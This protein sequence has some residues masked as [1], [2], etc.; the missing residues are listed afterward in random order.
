[1]SS[2]VAALKKEIAEL[3]EKIESLEFLLGLK[4]DNK[5]MNYLL[6]LVPFTYGGTGISESARVVRFIETVRQKFSSE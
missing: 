4:A 1:M 2:E 3:K 5:D 6:G